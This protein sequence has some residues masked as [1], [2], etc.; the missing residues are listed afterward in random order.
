MGYNALESSGAPE[1]SER[2]Y[3]APDER[4]SSAAYALIG[5][6]QKD[7]EIRKQNCHTQHKNIENKLGTVEANKLVDCSA[8]ALEERKGSAPLIGGDRRS[9][10]ENVPLRLGGLPK[11][12][13]LRDQQSNEPDTT[14][15][16]KD[17][18]ISSGGYYI[19]TMR[20]HGMDP[21]IR[22]DTLERKTKEDQAESRDRGM[23]L[24][25]LI[26]GATLGGR[27][28]HGKLALDSYLKQ[29]DEALKKPL[30]ILEKHLGYRPGNPP[31][32]AVTDMHSFLG[33]KPSY[34]AEISARN[35]FGVYSRELNGRALV[36]NEF[37]AYTREIGK[38]MGAGFLVNSTI[39]A[40]AF[41]DSVISNRTHWTDVGT[42][43]AMIAPI[44]QRIPLAGRV[45][46]IAGAHLFNRYLD[47]KEQH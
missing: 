12:I 36:Q 31:S 20:R 39:D 29:S 24:N 42:N 1:N 22:Q 3:N 44:A 9:N 28:I 10:S 33:T 11:A 13:T 23:L 16:A 4:Q 8:S 46:V 21:Y 45:G 37:K 18:P 38:T 7:A 15:Y 47:W 32:Y 35:A 25:G 19:G 6:F 27:T 17:A 30:Q 14:K 26:A 5:A 40:V 41:R 43:L 34:S 2:P